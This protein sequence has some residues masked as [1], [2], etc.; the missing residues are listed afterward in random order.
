MSLNQTEVVKVSAVV[1]NEILIAPETAVTLSVELQ[2]LF[3]PSQTIPE[4]LKAGTPISVGK[5]WGN[6][7]SL[8]SSSA[9]YD[10]VLLHDTKLNEGYANATVLIKGVVNLNAL[11]PEVQAKWTEEM[12]S[13][14]KHIIFVK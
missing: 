14:L 8:Y 2:P 6:R 13:Q 4:S 1:P 10:A 5:D 9:S 3:A 12:K 7:P 11:D